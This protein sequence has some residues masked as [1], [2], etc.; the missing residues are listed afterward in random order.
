MARFRIAAALLVPQ[1][2]ATELDGLRRALGSPERERVVPHV[3]LVSPTNL[4]DRELLV[5]L[6][7]LRSAA[8][9]V[10]GPLHLELGPGTS[11][12]PA[13]PTVHLAVA[14][15]VAG[16]E[17]VRAALRTGPL[18]RD[19]PHE[20]VPHVTLAQEA[21]PAVIEAATTLLHDFR[22]TV[23]IDRVHLLRQEAERRWVPIA[24]ARLGAAPGPVGRGGIEV[25]MAVTARPDP[26]GAALLAV[27]GTGPG[28][29]RPFAVTARREGRVV[30]AAW[31]WTNGGVAVVADLAVATAQRDLGIGRHLLTAVETEAAARG[32]SVALTVAPSDGA[33]AALLGGAGW[34]AAGDV[35]ADGRRLWRRTL[36]TEPGE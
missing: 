32:C 16:I 1:P 3:T 11:F 13:T 17:A 8:G 23:V 9:A 29:G 12:L 6:D 28:E 2:L 5:A 10:P 25:A 18:E 36:V 14:G 27:D 24:D 30:G 22:E 21:T 7:L 31:G 26:E 4:R 35:V 33:P 19:D 34:A 15:D 20:Y